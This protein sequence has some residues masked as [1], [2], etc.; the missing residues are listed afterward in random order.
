MKLAKDEE[1]AAPVPKPAAN[2]PLRRPE[3][4]AQLRE[5]RA[6]LAAEQ[7]V[8]AYVVFS[9]AS[10]ED[11]CEKMPRTP[12]EF[13][14]VSGVGKQKLERYGEA[15]LAAIRKAGDSEELSQEDMPF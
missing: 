7:N 1:K 13:L 12:A 2:S 15:F 3:L 6:R 10:L 5:L 4:F 9:N 11:M 14:T 8:P